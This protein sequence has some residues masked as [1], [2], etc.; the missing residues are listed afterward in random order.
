VATFTPTQTTHPDEIWHPLG[1]EFDQGRTPSL[2]LSEGDQGQ[3]AQQV[4]SRR[5]GRPGTDAGEGYSFHGT[6]RMVRSAL[7]GQG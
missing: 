2:V 7:R 3:T 6:A 1:G 4:E 5:Q